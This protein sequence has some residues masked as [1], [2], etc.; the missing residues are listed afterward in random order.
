MFGNRARRACFAVAFALLYMTQSAS[1]QIIN[2]HQWP[3]PRL[4]YLTPTGGKVGTT[5][6]VTFAGTEVEEPEALLFSHP[7]IKGTPVIPPLPP[8]DPKAKDKKEPVRPPITKFIVTIAKDVPV[9]AYDVRLVNK[10][11]VSNPRRFV[12]GDLNEVAEKEPNNDVEQAQKIEI[13]STINGTIAAATDVDYYSFAGKKGQRVLITCLAASIDSRLDPELKIYSPKGVELASYRPAPQQD[14]LVDVTCPE[15][16]D[17]LIR[18][19]KFTYTVANAEYFY[20]LSI[21]T[22]PHIDAL[23]P[24]MIEPGKTAQVTLYGRNLPGGKPDPASVVNGQMLEKLTVN[25]TA[26]AATDQLKY[27]G[28]VQPL[29]A[30]LDGFEYRLTGPTG[31]SNPML[32]TYARAPVVIENDDNDTPEK[33]QAVPIPCEIAG[34]IDK[35]RD[36]DWYV[37]EAKKGDVLMIEVFSARLGAPTDMYAVLKN[38]ATKQEF[39][40]QEDN[41]DSLSLRFF[42]ANNRDPVPYR[43]VAPAD[44]KYHLMLASHT[45]DNHADPTDVYRVRITKEQPDFR[46]FVMP[47]EETRPDSFRIGQGGTHHYTVFAQRSDG[48]KGDI[49]LTMEGLPAGVTCP[50]QTLAGG[51]RMTQ[52]VVN[53]ADN[54]APFTGRCQGTRNC[55]HQRSKGRASSSA[56]LRH[57]GRADSA[58]HPDD[59]PARSRTDAGR[60]RQGPR[61]A[62]RGHGQGG[63]VAR[64][65]D[66]DSAQADAVV[67]GVQGKLPGGAGA[68]RIAGRHRLRQPDLRARQRRCES[69]AHRGRQRAPRHLQ[70]RLPRLR[71]D[72]AQRQGEAGEHHPD[73]DAGASDGV[74]EAGG[75]T[76]GGQ[77]EPDD[78]DRRRRIDRRQSRPAIR[79]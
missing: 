62:G 31:T 43:F 50:P 77:R 39:A 64:R 69:D 42:T 6:E 4:N 61:Q 65:Q 46:L 28:L 5:V 10:H 53:A 56:R 22:A 47:A 78:Q 8:V 19:S 40:M 36:R 12:V 66:R 1:A 60:A 45:G 44:G 32:L 73:F 18:L 72:L 68:G 67:P 49:A 3:N 20:R 51:V 25:I 57:L 33:A 59:H 16:G 7:G 38:L 48:F 76:V 9:G 15:D 71:H 55:R 63:R 35:T 54:A 70:R 30:M 2:G 37:F 27:S 26:P 34:R 11:G 14:G 58:E 52:L 21:A 29:T 79:F 17:Y 23:F 75:D 74:A 41:V 13:G 24:P